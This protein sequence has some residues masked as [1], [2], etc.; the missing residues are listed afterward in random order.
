MNI[1]VSIPRWTPPLICLGILIYFFPN[2]RNFDRERNITVQVEN[3]N[4]GIQIE[5]KTDAGA[6]EVQLLEVKANQ[7]LEGTGGVIHLNRGG[8]VTYEYTEE[9]E[10]YTSIFHIESIEYVVLANSIRGECKLQGCISIA[11]QDEE[12]EVESDEMYI[13]LRSSEQGD[14]LIS[15]LQQFK[16][17]SKSDTTID[18]GIKR[19]FKRFFDKIF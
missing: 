14:K 18:T 1:N 6:N 11:K 2:V 4:D 10:V 15:F 5:N 8:I 12:K 7:L 19:R 9:D 3:M 13:M 16:E 17:I